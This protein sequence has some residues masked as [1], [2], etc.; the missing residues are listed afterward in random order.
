MAT[1]GIVKGSIMRIYVDDVAVA[2]ATDCS[3]EFSAAELT[4]S[5][6]D[7]SGSWSASDYGELNATISTSALYAA[8]DGE[9]FNDL[10]TAFIAGTKVTIKFSTEV[11]GDTYYSGE[12]LC[13]NLS[14][15]AP[16]NES[17]TY[18]ASFKSDGEVEEEVIPA[19]PEE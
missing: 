3:I 10:W 17:V 7:I 13:T 4:V 1:E 11:V 2:K 15:N 9:S 5:H 18:T 12:F 19:P 16:N 8:D 6:K 14:I